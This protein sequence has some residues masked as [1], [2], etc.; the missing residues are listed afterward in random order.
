MPTGTPTEPVF[1]FRYRRVQRTIPTVALE[2]GCR[3]LRS[4]SPRPIVATIT[5]IETADGHQWE[6][7]FDRH[8]VFHAG[9]CHTTTDLRQPQGSLDTLIEQVKNY[10]VQ[11]TKA[12]QLDQQT[13]QDTARRRAQ[14][15]RSQ[16]AELDR[17]LATA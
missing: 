6:A 7:S 14:S 12:F 10:V 11:Q 1:G 8:L 13:K 5:S 15:E 4:T 2:C 3:P 16:Q 17:L 9:H